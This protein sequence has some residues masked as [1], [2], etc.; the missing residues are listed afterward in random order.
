MYARGNLFGNPAPWAPLALLLQ[1][2]LNAVFKKM[3][4]VAQLQPYCSDNEEI[5]NNFNRFPISRRTVSFQE[6]IG[7]GLL[8]RVHTTANNPTH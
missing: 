2:I 7:M 5:Y 8:N 1:A 3:V 6:S 4:V